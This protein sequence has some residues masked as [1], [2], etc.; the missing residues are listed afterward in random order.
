MIVIT[1]KARVVQSITSPVH[2]AGQGH[3][4]ERC[5]RSQT[6]GH[7]SSFSLSVSDHSGYGHVLVVIPI[8]FFVVLVVRVKVWEL[9]LRKKRGAY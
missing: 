6:Q 7:G 4:L 5:L 2:T 8:H 1:H 3:M 9:K